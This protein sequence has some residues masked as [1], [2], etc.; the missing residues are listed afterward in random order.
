MCEGTYQVS[1]KAKND[2]FPDYFSDINVVTIEVRYDEPVCEVTS[3]NYHTQRISSFSLEIGSG[4]QQFNLEPLT[5]VPEC[6]TSFSL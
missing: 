5:Q 1:L 6:K 3:I 2:N 4:K